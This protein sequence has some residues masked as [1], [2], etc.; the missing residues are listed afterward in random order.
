MRISYRRS[1]FAAEETSFSR[2]VRHRRATDLIEANAAEHFTVD[3][4][5]IILNATVSIDTLLEILRGDI[6]ENEQRP[7]AGLQTERSILR[8][9][10]DL[11]HE[12]FHQ[13]QKKVRAI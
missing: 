6:V 7:I 3:G 4:I 12:E 11:S 10:R 13:L 1:N 8:Y 9:A 2:V 5:K